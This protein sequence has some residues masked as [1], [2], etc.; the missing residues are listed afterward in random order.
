MIEDQNNKKNYQAVNRIT[1]MTTTKIFIFK[2][3]QD[4]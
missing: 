3:I 4:I 1:F 2:T